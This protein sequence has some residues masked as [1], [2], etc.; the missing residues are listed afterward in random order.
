VRLFGWASRTNQGARNLVSR[1]TV[2]RETRYP[3]LEDLLR[4][5]SCGT[6]EEAG[7]SLACL[8]RALDPLCFLRHASRQHAWGGLVSIAL[9]VIE[10]LSLE[11]F[12]VDGNRDSS[13]IPHLKFQYVP[14]FLQASAALYLKLTVAHH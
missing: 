6:A 9:H 5:R 8:E 3:A 11:I 13:E 7:R 14:N 10:L 1:L 2:Y 4:A 12:Q